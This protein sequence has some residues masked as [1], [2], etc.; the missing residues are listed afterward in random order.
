MASKQS[1]EITK[2]SIGP[3]VKQS[4]Y[5]TTSITCDTAM[6]RFCQ[7]QIGRFLTNNMRFVNIVVTEGKDLKI[8]L[9]IVVPAN[10]RVCQNSRGLSEQSASKYV[11]SRHYM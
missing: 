3:V 11:P 10:S 9:R 2:S 7:L 6:S 1:C 4:S 5:K 8:E